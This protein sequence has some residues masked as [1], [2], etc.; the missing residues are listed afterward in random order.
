[1]DRHGCLRDT[2]AIY[3]TYF[4]ESF[5]VRVEQLTVDLPMLGNDGFDVEIQKDETARYRRVEDIRKL[6]SG[7]GTWGREVKVS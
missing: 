3:S 4:G 1:M 2:V 7:F 6:I 5:R